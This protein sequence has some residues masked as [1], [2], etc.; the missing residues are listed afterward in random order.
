MLARTYL[1]R[2]QR[3]MYE[4]LRDY[5]RNYLGSLS[6]ELKKYFLEYN[7]ELQ[8]FKSVSSKRELLLALKSSNLI[9]CGDY[10]TLPQAQRTVI[11]LLRDSLPSF[12]KRNK[13]F[14][15]LLEMVTPDDN[16]HIDRYLSGQ[17]SEAQFLKAISFNKNWGFNWENYRR[18][19]QFAQENSISIKGLNGPKIKT[20]TASLAAR[21]NFAAEVISKAAMENPDAILFVLVGDLHLA[22]KHLPE[23]VK[24]RLAKK[25][26]K[27]RLLTI[28]QNNDRFYWKLVEEGLEQF[29][30]VVKVEHGIFCVMNTPPWVK[31]QSYLRWQELITEA[32]LPMKSSQWDATYEEIDR[33]EDLRQSIQ[34][35]RNFLKLPEVP[36]DGFTLVGPSDLHFLSLA[37]EKK[38]LSVS[39]IR[40]ITEY[41]K[42]FKSQYI[43]SANLIYLASLSINH[44][45][46]QAAFYL[47]RQLTGFEKIFLSPAT[48][49][50]RFIWIEALGFLGSKIINHKRKCNGIK[51]LE[52]IAQIKD[53]KRSH[54]G[55]SKLARLVLDHINF[56]A[57][58]IQSRSALFHL[59]ASPG[60]PKEVT[61]Y[62]KATKLLGALLGHAI[63]RGLIEGNLTLNS[64]TRLY[65]LKLQNMSDQKV[66]KL[67]LT[68]ITR[69]DRFHYRYLDKT[70]EL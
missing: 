15:L 49:F 33:Y 23:K 39:Q 8:S 21:D 59:P 22:K 1:M 69:I 3:K 16:K 54:Y 4:N 57:G 29:I 14:I 9:F 56:E 34:C 17:V 50:Y 48:D 6:P 25:N 58:R 19:F 70:S 38:L 66:K 55:Q 7:Q 42:Q 27:P 62:Y 10:H 64:I 41:L 18:L 5:A 46:T 32:S 26:I 13:N 47:H 45:S 68:W 65:M 61:F 11:R 44:A 2:I 40:Q 30:D 28:H 60:D 43:P 51:N 24:T 36:M 31:L 35:I 37:A 12:K 67:Y 52:I 63:Y 53:S 20:K